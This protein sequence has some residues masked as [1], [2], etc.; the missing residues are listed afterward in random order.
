LGVGIHLTAV[1]TEPLTDG[2]RDRV[3]LPEPA[4]D[5]DPRAAQHLLG[6]VVDRAAVELHCSLE[7]RDTG[8][9]GGAFMPSGVERIVWHSPIVMPFVRC[10][11]WDL[12]KDKLRHIFPAHSHRERV[13]TM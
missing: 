6:K 8:A 2:E 4:P 3:S 1:G 11:K 5:A 13:C 10:C 12:R 9:A 7:E